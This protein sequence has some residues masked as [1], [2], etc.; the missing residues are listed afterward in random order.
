M[1]SDQLNIPCNN[2]PMRI[3]AMIQ[4]LNVR[5]LSIAALAGFYL[6]IVPSALAA[7]TKVVDSKGNV[8]GSLLNVTGG[9][10]SVQV[11]LSGA[12]TVLW[13]NRNGFLSGPT[14]QLIYYD[15][16]SCSGKAYLLFDGSVPQ[17]AI[18]VSDN[19][20]YPSASGKAYLPKSPEANVALKSFREISSGACTPF[21]NTRPVGAV[22]SFPIQGFVPPFSVKQ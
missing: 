1:R 3:T 16:D 15:G 4:A 12:I 5:S 22:E 13:L 6:N 19:N 21:P 7:D 20:S 2:K 10:S 18:F 11:S 14:K 8:I 17:T 9:A